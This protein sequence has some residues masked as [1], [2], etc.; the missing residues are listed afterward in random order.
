VGDGIQGKGF[1]IIIYLGCTFDN[2]ESI[3]RVVC[4]TCV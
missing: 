3:D 4:V 1:R 2:L